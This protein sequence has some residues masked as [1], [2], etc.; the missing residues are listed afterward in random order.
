MLGRHSYGQLGLGDTRA[1][2]D[3][4]GE[5]GDNLPTVALGT[6]RTAKAIAVG[7]GATCVILDTDLLKCWGNN[8]SGRLGLGDQN[9][10]SG[11]KNRGDQPN[12]MGDNL[13]TVA[14]GAGR[15]VKAV[16]LSSG[17]VT[18]ALL[19]NNQVKCWG[20]GGRLGLGDTRSRGGAPGE[21]G[22]ALPY[23]SFGDERS[24]VSLSLGDVS[25]CVRLDSNE[26]KCWGNNNFGVLG[27]G[28]TSTRGD[29]PGEMGNALPTVNLGREPGQ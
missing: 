23:V 12:E 17:S 10:L 29:A 11:M 22:D 28:D 26:I 24:V 4:S 21:M 20:T 6:G 18:C 25:A 19:D 3:N 5:M 8:L 2:G 14:L 27:I 15:T 16:D 13:P 7:A 9:D 1:R